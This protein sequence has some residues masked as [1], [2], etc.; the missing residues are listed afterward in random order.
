MSPVNA[1]RDYFIV[2]LQKNG[3]IP[4]VIKQGVNGRLNIK[5]VEPESKD[6]SFAFAFRIEVID[7][8]FL[9]FSDGIKAGVIVEKIG[10]KCQVKFR[11]TSD[12]R[13]GC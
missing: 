5:R 8:E 2:R 11:I 7:L 1:P 13:G 9:F 6:A 3:A 10:D 4:E 12:K